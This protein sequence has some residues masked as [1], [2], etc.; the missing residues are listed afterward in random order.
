[1]NGFFVPIYEKQK[2]SESPVDIKDWANMEFVTYCS[3]DILDELCD[4]ITGTM[5]SS[6]IARLSSGYAITT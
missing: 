3:S 5:P 4:D 6:C 2:V 1:M